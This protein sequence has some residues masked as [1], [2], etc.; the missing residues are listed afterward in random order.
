MSHRHYDCP[1]YDRHDKGPPSAGFFVGVSS[2]RFKGGGTI[3]ETP[4]QKAYAKRIME[5]SREYFSR[6]QPLQARAMQRMEGNQGAKESRARGM[7]NVNTQMAA[8]QAEQVANAVNANRGVSLGSGRQV[9]GTTGKV[10]LQVAGA[11]SAGK[12]AATS[13][14]QDQRYAG[15]SSIVAA[16]RQQDADSLGTMGDVANLSGQRA[17]NNAQSM[18]NY[19]SARGQILGQGL[20]L[21]AGLAGGKK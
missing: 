4:E 21:A 20:G 5:N 2:Q 15:L 10:G 9:V 11:L 16:G 19:R 12:A 17:A 3:Q 7:S 14:A 6:W 8:G 18:A 13:G 1:V